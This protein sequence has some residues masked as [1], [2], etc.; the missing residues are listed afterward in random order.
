MEIIALI[1]LSYIQNN[2]DEVGWFCKYTM[3]ELQD[4]LD[5][6]KCFTQLWKAPI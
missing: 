1:D 6:V 4:K 3:Y 2:M 5:V